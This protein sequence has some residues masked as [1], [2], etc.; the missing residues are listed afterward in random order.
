VVEG[1]LAH[2]ERIWSVG[3]TVAL[4][5]EKMARLPDFSWFN[6]PKARKCIPNNHKMYQTAI[7]HSKWS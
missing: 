1:E 4:R 2:R 5:A 3:V 7:K 6:I